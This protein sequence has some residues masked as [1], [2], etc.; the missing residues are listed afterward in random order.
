[1]KISKP[2]KLP[3]EATERELNECKTYASNRFFERIVLLRKLCRLSLCKA[4][5]LLSMHNKTLSKYERK[6]RTPSLETYLHIII[7]YYSYLKLNNISIPPD[8]ENFCKEYIP[9]NMFE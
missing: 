8:I 6:E 2:D 7:S 4:G 1:M 5:G 3:I 9:P